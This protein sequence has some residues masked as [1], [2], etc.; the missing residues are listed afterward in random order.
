MPVLLNERGDGEQM[1]GL[2]R[3]IH[4]GMRVFDAMQT[5]IGVVDQ[6]NFS[7]EDPAIP[8]S[9]AASIRRTGLAGRSPLMEVI[10][11]ALGAGGMPEIERE[12]LISG[13]HVS[14]NSHG[15][16][17]EADRLIM[18]SQIQRVSHDQLFLNVEMSKL[19]K[20]P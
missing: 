18:S 15:G 10:A 9:E 17:F 13:G 7:D 3:E 5:E 11:T 16:V 8:G 20:R 19:I 2:A 1:D 12:R 6:V 14:I 4:K